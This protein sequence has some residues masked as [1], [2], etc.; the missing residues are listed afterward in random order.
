M[1]IHSL[2]VV[3]L[4]GGVFSTT[5]HAAGDPIAGQQK[6]SMCIGCHGI[7]GWRNAY[8]QV[9]SIPKLGGQHADYIVKALKAYKTGAR[10]HETMQAIATSL[11]EQDMV[12]LAAYYS[13]PNSKY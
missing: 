11:T 8:P 2:L 5:S 6:N 1:R 13:N 7:E 10:K 12:D 9:Y 3:L 4:A